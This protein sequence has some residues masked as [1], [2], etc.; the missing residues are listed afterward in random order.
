MPT[1]WMEQI[2]TYYIWKNIKGSNGVKGVWALVILGIRESD[3][4]M[5]SKHRLN[6]TEVLTSKLQLPNINMPTKVT[7]KAG[8]CYLGG[9]G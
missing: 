2:F 8:E 9:R 7:G 3:I 1:T 5:Y 6:N 4:V